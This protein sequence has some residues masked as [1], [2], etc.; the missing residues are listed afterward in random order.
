MLV[1]DSNNHHFNA[2]HCSPAYYVYEY[3][4][5]QFLPLP[6]GRQLVRALTLSD[7]YTQCCMCGSIGITAQYKSE[8]CNLYA[9]NFIYTKMM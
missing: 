7:E 2:H 1:W 4:K 6:Q 9:Y 5:F 3:I 8:D